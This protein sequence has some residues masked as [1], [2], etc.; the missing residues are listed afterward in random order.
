MKVGVYYNNYDVRIEER[1]IPKISDNDILLKIM[2]SGICGSDLMEFHRKKKAPFVPGHEIAGIIEEVG[3]NIT[4]YKPGDRIFVTHHVPCDS[5]RECLHDYKTQCYDFKN[6]NNFD[7]GGFADYVRVTGKSLETGIIKLPDNMTYE[8]A[9]FIEPLGTAVEIA[10]K[11]DGDTVLVLGSGVAG[12]LNIQLSKSFGAGKVIATDTNNYRRKAAEK[13]GADYAISSIDF[14]P[15]ILRMVNDGRLADKIII[16]TGAKK[17]TEQAFQSY[18]Q[19]GEIIFFATPPENEKVEIEWYQHWRNGLKTRV[20]YG[21]TPKS[22]QTAFALIKNKK[23]NVDDMITHRLP[24]EEIAKGFEIASD[25][26]ECLKVIIE[27]HQ[28]E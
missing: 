24:L 16:C 1:A 12:L 18:A 9:S 4:K 3:N 11:L 27:P 20:T 22:N 10:D 13:F 21:A 25:S 2:A 28:N 26:K 7:P 15:D 14:N 19:G 6:I 17:A 5:C 8:Q 23:I